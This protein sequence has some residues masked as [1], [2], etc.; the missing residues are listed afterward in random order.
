MTADFLAKLNAV[1][2]IYE[3]KQIHRHAHK[4]RSMTIHRARIMRHLRSPVNPPVHGNSAALP[5]RRHDL[6]AMLSSAQLF[7]PIT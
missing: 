1:N 5:P 6:G 4:V 2:P 7:P 3:S